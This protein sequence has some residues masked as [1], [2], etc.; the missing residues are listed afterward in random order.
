[1][2]NQSISSAKTKQVIDSSKKHRTPSSPPSTEKK[3]LK[4]DSEEEKSDP[5]PPPVPLFLGSG[6]T[7]SYEK[8]LTQKVTTYRFLDQNINK[9]Q[10]N[11]NSLQ[12]NLVSIN[13]CL[14]QA[15]IYKNNVK[16]S[17]ENLGIPEQ[18]LEEK[19]EYHYAIIDTPS[20][21]PSLERAPVVEHVKKKIS[22]TRNI[23]GS[24]SVPSKK[25][26]TKKHDTVSS[27]QG[28]NL[29]KDN[30]VSSKKKRVSDLHVESK[31]DSIVTLGGSPICIS[32]L[33][34][35]PVDRDFDFSETKNEEIIVVS[36]EDDF[37]PLPI[38]QE[39]A[40]PKVKKK[41]KKISLSSSATTAMS[42]FPLTMKTKKKPG[43]MVLQYTPE[44]RVLCF[45]GCGKSFSN[46]YNMMKHVKD[47]VCTKDVSDRSGNYVCEFKK[48]TYSCVTRNALMMHYFG[49][50]RIKAYACEVASCGRG[51]IHA[52]SLTNHKHNDHSDIYGPAPCQEREKYFDV[53]DVKKKK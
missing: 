47:E 44:N 3:R 21:D 2:V 45:K 7:S 35:E 10:Q 23:S 4:S 50:L 52:S 9:L 31:D 40:S 13:S 18:I 26:F 6:E 46:K 14:A 28:K 32:L 20:R 24:E 15:E 12:K 33:K 11:V 51:F 30:P 27:S 34:S 8:D 38:K 22:T 1:M 37:Q 5:P 43:E 53:V 25:L 42:P 17:L 49:H 36:S 29:P 16:M 19:E 39:P 41:K 48:C